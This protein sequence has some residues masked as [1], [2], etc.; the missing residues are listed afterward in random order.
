M[1][2]RFK[3]VMQKRQ[4]R[5]G[6]L[7]KRIFLRYELTVMIIIALLP[8]VLILEVSYLWIETNIEREMSFLADATARRAGNILKVTQTNLKQLAE[9]TSARCDQSAVNF[10]RDKVFNVMY[11]REIGI[12]NDNKLGISGRPC[13]STWTSFAIG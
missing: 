4:R 5:G 10:M 3:G 12:I 8:E 2:P 13:R 7:T 11:I 1:L 6:K 9:Q